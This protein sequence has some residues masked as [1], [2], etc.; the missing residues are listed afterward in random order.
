MMGPG[1]Q[2]KLALSQE[3]IAVICGLYAV[4]ACGEAHDIWLLPVVR[5]LLMCL[6]LRHD[7]Q[8]SNSI[9]YIKYHILHIIYYILYIIYYIVYSI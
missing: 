7:P 9:P 4:E 5:C 2:T 1:N 3:A 8:T 6:V